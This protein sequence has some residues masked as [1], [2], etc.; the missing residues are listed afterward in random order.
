MFKFL[1]SL[2]K[3]EKHKEVY[4]VKKDT[5]EFINMMAEKEKAV[6]IYGD[7]RV[8]RALKDSYELGKKK[9]CS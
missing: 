4:G 2:F 9:G 6:N 1:K 8:I 7:Y 5:D 3:K